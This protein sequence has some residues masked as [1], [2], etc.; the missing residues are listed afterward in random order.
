MVFNDVASD[1]IGASSNASVHAPAY[2]PR[3]ELDRNT[4]LSKATTDPVFRINAE[5]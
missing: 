3:Y 2:G 4:I 1:I 5:N